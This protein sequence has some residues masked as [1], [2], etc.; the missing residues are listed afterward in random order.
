VNESDIQLIQQAKRGDKEAFTQLVHNYKNYVFKSAFAILG[1]REEARDVSQE[2]FA[3]AYVSLR[4]LKDASTFPSWLGTI[5]TRMSIDAGKRK[6][7]QT[8]I[9]EHSIGEELGGQPPDSL[10][11]VE[12]RM[13]LEESLARLR[14]DERV[15]F[16]LRELQDRTYQEIAD[17]LAIPVGTVRSRLHSA[18]HNL[19]RMIGGSASHDV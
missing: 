19:R 1:D 8:P 10:S 16:V 3:K 9:G 5:V 15:I 11:A 13:V 7:R 2:A 17:I 14:E 18:R 12:R 4:T 6:K